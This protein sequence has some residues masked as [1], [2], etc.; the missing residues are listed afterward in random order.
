MPNYFFCSRILF[1]YKKIRKSTVENEFKSR[2]DDDLADVK[3]A[4]LAVPENERFLFFLSAVVLFDCATSIH[5][6]IWV[7]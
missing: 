5:F 3:V 7:I 1:I 4:D 2:D 6:F